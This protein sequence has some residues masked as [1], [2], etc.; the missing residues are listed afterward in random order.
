MNQRWASKAVYLTD[1]LG[2]LMAWFGGAVALAMVVVGAVSGV[3][4]D[5]SQAV[6]G[7]VLAVV[8]GGL[9]VARCSVWPMR[10]EVDGDELR[11]RYLRGTQV[12]DVATVT[13]V[14]WSPGTQMATIEHAGGRI[15]VP[16]LFGLDV[17]MGLGD[18]VAAMRATNPD[19]TIA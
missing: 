13:R 18:V 4:G 5:T 16:A 9:L 6:A 2:G 8:L 14:A 3:H 19:I 17:M 11:C 12:I 1:M 7:P 10:V 15:R